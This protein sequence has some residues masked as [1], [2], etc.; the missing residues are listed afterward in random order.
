MSFFK[1][2]SN[3]K[4]ITELS[5]NIKTNIIKKCVNIKNSKIDIN[6]ILS[7]EEIN[8]LNNNF[9]NDVINNYFI[10]ILLCK[11]ALDYVFTTNEEHYHKYINL[12]FNCTSIY[13]LNV[14]KE[15]LYIWYEKNSSEEINRPFNSVLEDIYTKIKKSNKV[16]L[17]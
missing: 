3:A 2:N 5:F 8:T 15:W 17:V 7:N 16:S 6:L 13:C 4:R 9:N 11:K 1:K 14:I 12:T 10:E